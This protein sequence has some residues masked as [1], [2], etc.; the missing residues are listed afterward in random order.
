MIKK[1]NE[2]LALVQDAK[3]RLPALQKELNANSFSCTWQIEEEHDGSVDYMCRISLDFG[4]HSNYH[5][6]SYINFN[7][8]FDAAA[9]D[10]REYHAKWLQ[11]ESKWQQ[12]QQEN[13]IKQRLYDEYLKQNQPA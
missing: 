4:Q 10:I 2:F 9:S 12:K 7:H 8:G 5:A 1:V 6:G 3:D 11:D 13:E